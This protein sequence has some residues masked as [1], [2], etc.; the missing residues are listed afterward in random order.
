MV[1]E[2]RDFPLLSTCPTTELYMPHLTSSL[3]RGNWPAHSVKATKLLISQNRLAERY[4]TQ[5][6]SPQASWRVLGP[7]RIREK[8]NQSGFTMKGKV[9]G[10][11]MNM[12]LSEWKERRVHDIRRL[13]RETDGTGS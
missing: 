13:K 2:L 4:N 8:R 3:Q 1:I 9:G 5:S 12:I 10:H 6:L 7:H 11:R